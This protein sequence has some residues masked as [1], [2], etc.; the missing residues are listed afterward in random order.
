MGMWWWCEP[1]GPAWL[2]SSSCWEPACWSWDPGS[3]TGQNIEPVGMKLTLFLSGH[4]KS[5]T[6]ADCLDLRKTGKRFRRMF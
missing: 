3:L 4:E 5:G 2:S 1:L 6:V